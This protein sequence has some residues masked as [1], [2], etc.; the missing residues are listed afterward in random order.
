M[1]AAASASR[2]CAARP[3]RGR[4]ARWSLSA[5]GSDCTA[6]QPRTAAGER[7]AEPG[8]A[9]S[10]PRLPPPSAER[11]LGEIYRSCADPPVPVPLGLARHVVFGAITHARGLGSEPHA[12]FV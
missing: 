11:F 6:G 7:T 3:S 1:L 4:T 5:R 8:E 10:G 12:D 9:R 2:P